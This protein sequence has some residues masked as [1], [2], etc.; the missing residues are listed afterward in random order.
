MGNTGDRRVSRR[1]RVVVRLWYRIS[2]GGTISRW[3][4]GKT[5]DLSST[6][7]SFRCGHSLA[8]A[9]RLEMVIDWP[10]KRGGIHPICLRA[11]GRVVRSDDGKIAVWTTSCRMVIEKATSP[12]TAACMFGRGAPRK[13]ESNKGGETNERCV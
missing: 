3:R 9:A 8:T 2:G 6:G 4:A 7:V 11:A 10:S 5:C 12:P 13:L 1:Y